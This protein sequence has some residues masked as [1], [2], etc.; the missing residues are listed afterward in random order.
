MNN[1]KTESTEKPWRPTK[2]E[3]CINLPRPCG[4]LG[5]RYNILLDV[6]PAGGII[7]NHGREVEDG[8]E[9]PKNITRRLPTVGARKI[10]YYN[11]V[12]EQNIEKLLVDIEDL[13]ES[14]CLLDLVENGKTYTLE[15]TGDLLNITRERV[16]QIESKALEHCKE[17]SPDEMQE[18]KNR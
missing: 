8:T 7:F 15:E 18:W 17:L 2:R 13:P 11:N 4:Y 3:D 14:N 16:R 6:T 1:K 9:R 12:L 10:P 5:C